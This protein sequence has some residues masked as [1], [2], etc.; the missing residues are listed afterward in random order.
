MK[1]TAAVLNPKDY[2]E[3]FVVK[4]F[5]SRLYRIYECIP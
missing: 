1:Y 3:L 2:V 4:S 5:K